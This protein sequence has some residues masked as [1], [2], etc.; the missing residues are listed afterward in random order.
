MESLSGGSKYPSDKG[1]RG[2]HPDPEIRGG[3]G[4]QKTFLAL[5]ALFRSK[6]K[7]EPSLPASPLD[8]QLPL[9][10]VFDTLQYFEAI[11]PLLKSL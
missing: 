3:P 5:R 4:L 10:R 11:L 6:N 8:P 7:G 2:G 9:P 1:G